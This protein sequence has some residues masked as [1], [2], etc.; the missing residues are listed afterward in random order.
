[1]TRSAVIII[2]CVAVVLLTPLGAAAKPLTGYTIVVLEPL[3]V[4]KGDA[5]KDF[6]DGW[7]I[8]LHKGMVRQLE[9]KKLFSQVIDG[10]ATATAPAAATGT[11]EKRLLLKS[12]LLVYSKGSRAARFLVGMGAG[13]AKTRIRFTFVDADSGQE[14]LTTEREGKFAGWLNPTGGTNEDAILESAGDVV[15][16]LIDDIRKNR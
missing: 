3:T 16:R 11:T 14:L 9:K 12:T 2:A 4:E 10:A 15:D 7:E 1:M 6:Q 5:T 8:L 13:A